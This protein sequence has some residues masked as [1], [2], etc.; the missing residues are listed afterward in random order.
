MGNSDMD[1][2]PGTHGSHF[3]TSYGW[4]SNSRCGDVVSTSHL[5]TVPSFGK[6]GISKQ[7]CSPVALFANDL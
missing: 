3:W 1:E 7:K 2:S 6:H 4:L 5:T